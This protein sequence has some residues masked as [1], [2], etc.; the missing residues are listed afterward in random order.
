MPDN[1][2]RQVPETGSPLLDVKLTLDEQ[3]HL[4]KE[5]LNFEIDQNGVVYDEEGDEFFGFKRNDKYDFS[6]LRGIIFYI[7]EDAFDLGKDRGKSEIHGGMKKL[8]DIPG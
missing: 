2:E 1:Q 7:K 3:R 4:L 8:L 5:L 6:T